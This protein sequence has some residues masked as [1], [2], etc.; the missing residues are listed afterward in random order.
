MEKEQKHVSVRTKGQE[1]AVVK[2]TFRWLMICSVNG[3]FYNRQIKSLIMQAEPV[4]CLGSEESG[5]SSCQSPA[6]SFIKFVIGNNF[7]S[8]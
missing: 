5:S 1:E 2:N 6:A 8:V 3:D 4:F 7:T